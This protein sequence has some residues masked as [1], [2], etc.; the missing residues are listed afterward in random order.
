MSERADGQDRAAIRKEAEAAFRAHLR[1]SSGTDAAGAERRAARLPEAVGAEFLAILADYEALRNAGAARD[2]LP[3]RIGDF[4]LL[5]EIGRGGMGEVWEARQIS[6][7]RRVALKLLHS[8]LGLSERWIERFQREAQAG[9]RLAHTGIVTVHAVGEQDGRHFIAQELVGGDTLADWIERRRA[10]PRLPA[11][12]FDRVARIIAAVADALHSAHEAGILHLDVKPGNVLLPDEA[13]PKIADFGLAVAAEESALTR[14]GEVLGTPYYMSPEQ[15][16]ARRL[17]PDRR[18]DV[19]ALG[20]TLYE[21]LTLALP[22]PGDTREQVAGRILLEEPQDPRRLRSQIPRDLAVVCLKALLKNPARR[23]PAMAPLAADLRRHPDLQPVAARPPSPLLRAASWLR[24][25]PASGAAI[26]VGAVAMVAISLLWLD[27]R[28]ARERADDSAAEAVTQAATAK[29][30][31]DFLLGLFTAGT[32]GA[33]QGETVTLDDVL[34]RGA[35]R[36]RTEPADDPIT[37]AALMMAIGQ[38]YSTLGRYAEAEPLLADAVNLRLR[39]VGS[40]DQRTLAAMNKLAQL[41]NAQARFEEAERWYLLA[42]EGHVR[43]YGAE[44]PQEKENRGNLGYLYWRTKRFDEAE[45]LLLASREGTLALHGEDSEEAATTTG[46]LGSLF[47]KQDRLEEAERLLEQAVAMRR[48]KVGEK[49]PAFL[50]PFGAL[51]EAKARLGRPDAEAAMREH[52]RLTRIVFG[53]DL[54]ETAN[55]WNSLGLFLGE[56]EASAEAVACFQRALEIRRLRLRADHPSLRATLANLVKVLHRLDRNEE[57]LP[58]AE[59]LLA[60]TPPADE[61]R[62]GREILLAAIREALATE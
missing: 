17:P 40:G 55:S 14:T 5:R 30:I 58:L 52:L 22:F 24:R 15:L 56:R 10:L 4:E 59:E 57:A 12:H 8:H 1:D 31:E 29:S 62:A 36:A 61:S 51:A 18:T 32:P 11:D 28:A 7:D 35:E 33:R 41:L 45:P 53:E 6:L 48:A 50:A 23:Y 16:S 3:Q 43:L 46:N 27:A 60:L 2:A 25:H 39:T 34:A 42:Q 26:G 44:S 9:G 54:P 49:S 38:A 13:R 47:L 19:F 20:A 21:A 37:R